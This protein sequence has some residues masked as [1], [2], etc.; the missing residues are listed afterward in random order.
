M[1]GALSRWLLEPKTGVFVGNPNPR[2]REK[3]WEKVMS[4]LNEGSATMIVSSR[5]PQGYEVV[6]A[7][8]TRRETADFDGL[9]LIRKV[10]AE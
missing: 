9:T 6:M 5:S 1:R 7:G 4:R 10:L 2:V 3:L 8:E